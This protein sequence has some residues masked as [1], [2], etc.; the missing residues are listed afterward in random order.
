MSKSRKKVEL[1]YK[2]NQKHTKV[3]EE[4]GTFYAV[5]IN[6]KGIIFNNTKNIK[7]FVL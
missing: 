5:G 2:K 1:N 7:S 3:I 4:K 6:K